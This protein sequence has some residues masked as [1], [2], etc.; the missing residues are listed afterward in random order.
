MAVPPTFSLAVSRLSF[1][2]SLLVQGS[3]TFASR[4]SAFANRPDSAVPASSCA[5]PRLPRASQHAGAHAHDVSSRLE[6][7]FFCAS[8]V[9]Q[10]ARPLYPRPPRVT[11]TPRPI[12]PHAPLAIPATRPLCPRASR[13]IPTRERSA[14]PRRVSFQPRDRS[15][16]ARRVSFK[17][18]DRSILARRV[19]SQPHAR[20]ILARHV[21]PKPHDPSALPRRVSSRAPNPLSHQTRLLSAKDLLS[22]SSVRGGV[23]PGPHVPSEEIL[24]AHYG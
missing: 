4:R 24:R 2:F 14:L 3:S 21:S 16:L 17:S 18:R 6:A 7:T 5:R 23:S 12:C 11:Q 1:F 19:S 20:S 8:R 22:D 15:A 13:V 10:T 9:L